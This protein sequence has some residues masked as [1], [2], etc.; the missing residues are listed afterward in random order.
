[1]YAGWRVVAGTFFAQMMVIGFFIYAGSLLVEPVRAEFG[2][3]LEQVM[4]AMTGATL[5][6]FVMM[7]LGGIAIDRYPARYVMGAGAAFGAAA[8]YGLSQATSIAGYVI[9]FSIAMSVTNAFVGSTSC[10]T[11]ISRWFNKSRGR[12]LGISAIGTSVGGIVIPAAFAASLE[13]VGW[14]MSLQYM[15][16]LYLAILLPIVLFSISSSPQEAGVGNDNA[17][18]AVSGE[19]PDMD[20]ALSLGDILRRPGYWYMGLSLGLLFSVY[21]AA[22]A[23]ITPYALTQGLTAADA[24]T[25]IMIVAVSGLV[26][27]VV[28]GVVADRTSPKNGLWIAQAL[29]CVSFVLLAGEPGYLI[30]ALAFAALGLAA[31]G[32]LPV[33]GAM[34]ARVF[35]LVSYGRAMGIMGP[36]VT[37]CVL[38]GFPVVGRLVDMS[39][40]YTLCFQ[41]FSVV[42]LVGALVLFPLR[43]DA[44]AEQRL[45]S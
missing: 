27:K 17:E 37:I 12:A 11:V 45:L 10:S 22:M 19:I 29:V 7:P 38:P 6:G 13:A 5:A 24:S 2:A 20:K 21:S 15:S 42:V 43:L 31:G 23:N 28:L 32:M 18:T 4:Y 33:W 35:G 44:P 36:L 39:G 8:L 34:V 25:F 9:L 41:V 30:I 26:G 1:M 40:S 16:L 14:R 3:T